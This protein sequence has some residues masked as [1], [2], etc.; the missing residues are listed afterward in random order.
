MAAAGRAPTAAELDA[1]FGPVAVAPSPAPS[2]ALQVLS[3]LLPEEEVPIRDLIQR[4]GEA[5]VSRDR[6]ALER[7]FADA[8][9]AAPLTAHL[10]Q[11]AVVRFDVADAQFQFRRLAAGHV[12]VEVERIRVVRRVG[13]RDVESSGRKGF[14][15]VLSGGQA[16]LLQVGGAP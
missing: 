11:S 1:L 3:G 2:S 4:Y 14:R 8:A 12:W 7:L 15:V 6:A 9:Q 10:D 16:R 13:G 5:V